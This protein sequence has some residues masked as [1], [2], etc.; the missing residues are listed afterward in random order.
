MKTESEREKRER[1]GEKKQYVVRDDKY[2]MNGTEVILHATTR[3]RANLVGFFVSVSGGRKTPTSRAC[4]HCIM[5]QMIIG[6]H[7]F[8][9]FYFI[10]PWLTTQLAMTSYSSQ[11]SVSPGNKISFGILYMFGVCAHPLFNFLI[12]TIYGNDFVRLS[13]ARHRK[14]QLLEVCARASFAINR[15]KELVDELRS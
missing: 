15:G 5:P 13:D 6:W 8:F 7:G 4:R 2:L 12:W 1:Y 11:P 3:Q 9:D 10:S 14:Q